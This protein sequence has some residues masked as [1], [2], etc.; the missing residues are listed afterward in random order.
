MDDQKAEEKAFHA[1]LVL[2]VPVAASLIVGVVCAL[3]ILVSDVGFPTVTLLPE[4]GFGPVINAAIF[5]SLTGLGA[6]MIYLFLKRKMKGLIRFLIGFAITVVTF[7]ISDLYFWMLISFLNVAYVELLALAGAV[8]VTIVV[9]V[10][11]FAL[12]NIGGE[13]IILALGGALG[14][15]LGATIPTFSAVLILLFLA[16]Y[17]VLAVFR[18]PVGKIATEGLEYV[19]GLSFSFRDIQMG[20]GDLTFYSM[21]VGHGLIFFG[22]WACI[23]GIVGVLMGSSLSF[24]MLEKKGMFP[25]L[26]FSIGLGLFGVLVAVILTGF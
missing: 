24:K 15:F 8:L 23:G 26:P 18:G 22:V 12:R 25:G 7:F 6:S 4:S 9:D 1:R 11:L 3:L 14:T 5:V 13:I 16:A 19:R 17:D 21:L 2:L 10:E 20:L